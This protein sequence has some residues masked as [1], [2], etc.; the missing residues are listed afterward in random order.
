MEGLIF[1]A[2]KIMVIGN[3]KNSRVFNLMLAKY[4]L[5]YM[6]GNPS[7]LGVHMARGAFSEIM[8]FYCT[9]MSGALN[10]TDV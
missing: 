10:L 9:V 7:F 8:R 3:S 1:S 2:D 4:V 5:Q 6:A